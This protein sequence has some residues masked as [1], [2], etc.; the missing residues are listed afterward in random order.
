MSQPRRAELRP[1]GG[2][3]GFQLAAQ[4]GPVGL[5]RWR[6]SLVLVARLDVL[7]G[8]VRVDR[9]GVGLLR[10]RRKRGSIALRDA[11]VRY[12]IAVGGERK[13]VGVLRIPRAGYRHE[14]AF[15]NRAHGDT[16]TD[17]QIRRHAAVPVRSGAAPVHAHDS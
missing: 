3:A 4:A 1:R 15:G 2:L 14:S 8:A 16:G 6:V 11:V 12:S 7:I 13:A 5:L 10:P 9:V 17:V